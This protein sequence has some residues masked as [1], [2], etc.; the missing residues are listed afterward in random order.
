MGHARARRG[1]A[2]MICEEA[3]DSY[4]N[5]EAHHNTP[6]PTTNT[7][8]RKAQAHGV[9]VKRRRLRRVRS[10]VGRFDHLRYFRCAISGAF[11]FEPAVRILSDGVAVKWLLDGD[12]LRSRIHDRRLLPRAHTINVRDGMGDGRLCEECGSQVLHHQHAIEA[13]AWRSMYFH[14]ECFDIW[15]RERRAVLGIGSDKTTGPRGTS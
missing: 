8:K 12:A 15:D 13:L 1:D 14:A 3:P 6:S 2:R 10:L 5:L 7:T 11:P 4:R 9:D